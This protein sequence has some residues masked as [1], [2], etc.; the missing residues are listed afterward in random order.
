[1][2]IKNMFELNITIAQTLYKQDAETIMNMPSDDLETIVA[3]VAK[4]YDENNEITFVVEL[5]MYCAEALAWYKDRKYR[6]E[7]SKL[8]EE[9]HALLKELD[10]I[11]ESI[12]VLRNSRRTVYKAPEHCPVTRMDPSPVGIREN[13][14]EITLA[15]EEEIII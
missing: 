4:R 6:E 7:M 12:R 14:G 11:N 9:R 1:M 5:S 3:H 15:D 13:V 8:M 2:I 10:S